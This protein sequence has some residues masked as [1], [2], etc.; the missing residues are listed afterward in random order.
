L[1]INY[2]VELANLAF[3]NPYRSD[4]DAARVDLGR[5]IGAPSPG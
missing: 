2:A 4:S 1:D 3:R 5:L